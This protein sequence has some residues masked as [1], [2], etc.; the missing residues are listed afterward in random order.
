MELIVTIRKEVPD[1]ET[2]DD[3]FE[4]VK[5]RLQ[6]KPGLRISGMINNHFEGLVTEGEPE[7]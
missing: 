2:G 4:L 1:Q 3:L 6:D 5:Q 7:S